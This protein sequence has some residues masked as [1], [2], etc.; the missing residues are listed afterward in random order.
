MPKMFTRRNWWSRDLGFKVQVAAGRTL[1]VSSET[2]KRDME[3][4]YPA[5]RDRAHVVQFAMD[6]DI[7]AYKGRRAEMQAIYAIPGRFFYLPN[8]FWRHKNHTVIVAALAQLKAEG[9]LTMLP[10]VLLSGLQIDPRNPGYFENVMN[11]VKAAGVESH[12]RHLGLIPYEHVLSLIGCCDA[13]LNPSF[14]E[15]WSTPIE[16]AKALGAPLILS[17][18]PIHRE[19]APG[20]R[21]FDP[22]SVDAAASVLHEYG[23]LST[24]ASLST[25][26]LIVANE[27][28]LNRH[29]FSLLMTIE[30]ARAGRRQSKTRGVTR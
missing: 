30:D 24:V 22:S 7:S 28:R 23:A 10:T 21:F 19:Q 2:A 25:A 11:E 8:Q 6:M 29:A 3:S 14:F 12:F 5:S 4:F 9:R 16:E 13:L 18:I 26:E 1:M 17:D 15:G 27:A 20:A